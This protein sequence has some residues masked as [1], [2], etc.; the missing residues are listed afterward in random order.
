[1][2]ESV[3][4]TVNFKNLMHLFICTQLGPQHEP[5]ATLGQRRLLN[6][7]I[8]TLTASKADMVIKEQLGVMMVEQMN[9]VPLQLKKFII[10]LL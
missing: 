3:I 10:Q 8:N 9:E 2:T 1:M 6:K 7:I 4:D 5:N